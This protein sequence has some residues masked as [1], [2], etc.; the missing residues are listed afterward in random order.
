MS[1]ETL[2]FGFSPVKQVVELYHT[3]TQTNKRDNKRLLIPQSLKLG[4]ARF[5]TNLATVHTERIQPLVFG[6]F[7]QQELLRL[8]PPPLLEHN[9]RKRSVSS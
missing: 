2:H 1:I 4:A 8:L 5:K 3:K 9:G 6:S 7:F